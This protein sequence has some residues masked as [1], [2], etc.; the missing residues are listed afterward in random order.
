MRPF[1]LCVIVL[2]L[3]GAF[4]PAGGH[5]DELVPPGS[6]LELLY[7]RSAPIKGGLTEGVAAAPDGSMYFSEIPFGDDKGMIMR[8]D[9]RTKTTT[10]FAARQPQVERP[11]VRRQGRSDR[12]RGVRRRRPLRG[13]MGREDRPARGHRRP[14]HGQAIQRL[15]RPLHRRKGADLLHRSPLPGHRAA[16]AGIPRRLSGRH[17]RHGRR[18]SRTTSRSPTASRSAPTR[19]RSTSPTTTTAPTGSTRPLRRPRRAR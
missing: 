14:V 5:A 3:I 7:T 1:S 17:R 10:V 18:E 6:K 16:R 15:Q 4:A 8:F 9:P 12:L 19:R 11:D 2:L 13:A